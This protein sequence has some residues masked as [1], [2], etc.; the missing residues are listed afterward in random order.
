MFIKLLVPPLVV[1]SFILLPLNLGVGALGAG[2]ALAIASGRL[3]IGKPPQ[4]AQL[5]KFDDEAYQAFAG[6]S[7]N[8]QNIFS[9]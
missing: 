9:S 6:G 8:A 1:A 4:L 5:P 3:Y 7:T 2:F